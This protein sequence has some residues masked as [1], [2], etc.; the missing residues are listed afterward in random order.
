MIEYENFNEMVAVV[1]SLIGS[2]FI[3]DIYQSN[4]FYVFELSSGVK[5]KMR[6]V[7]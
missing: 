2:R 4:D 3:T 7:P 5:L 1:K 6:F